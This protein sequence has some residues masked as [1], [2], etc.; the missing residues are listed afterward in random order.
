MIEFG[1]RLLLL[2]KEIKT[3]MARLWIFFHFICCRVGGNQ[4]AAARKVK[5]SHIFAFLSFLYCTPLA[6]EQDKLQSTC[7]GIFLGTKN[8]GERGGG[9]KVLCSPFTTAGLEGAL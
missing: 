8:S 3:G 5:K 7:H 9:A 2:A 1:S 4:R 6:S